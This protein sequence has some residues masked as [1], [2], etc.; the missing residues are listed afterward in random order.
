MENF[1]DYEKGRYLDFGCE[2]FTNMAFN[3][4][5]TQRVTMNVMSCSIVL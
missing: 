2:T 4:T 5:V 1:H 3:K